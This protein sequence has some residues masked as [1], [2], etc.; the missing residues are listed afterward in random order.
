MLQYRPHNRRRKRRPNKSPLLAPFSLT[1][2]Q[3]IDKQRERG[4]FMER[5]ERKDMREMTRLKRLCQF[6]RTRLWAALWK[7]TTACRYNIC[8][9][10]RNRRNNTAHRT[11]RTCSSHRRDVVP[12]RM[13]R[14][15]PCWQWEKIF[16][17][18]NYRLEN[19][20]TWPPPPN[21]RY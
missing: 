6:R 7:W 2:V 14:N 9:C 18:P 5:T 15:V 19:R 20:K 8:R 3:N 16:S 12:D 10:R 4:F 11:C 1:V 17:Y 21:N 13:L